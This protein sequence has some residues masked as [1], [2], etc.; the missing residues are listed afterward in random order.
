[1]PPL[2]NIWYRA[3]VDRVDRIPRSDYWTGEFHLRLMY[4]KNLVLDI[5]GHELYIYQN[6]DLY[7]W[8]NLNSNNL[9]M[10]N[11]LI[12]AEEMALVILENNRF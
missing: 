6:S 1:M 9:L 10:T 3:I 12:E 4:F 2:E 8:F 11:S 7:R 5:A